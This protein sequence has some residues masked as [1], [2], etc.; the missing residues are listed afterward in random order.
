MPDKQYNDKKL[1]TKGHYKDV[2]HKWREPSEEAKK[3]IEEA[4]EDN[5]LKL[6]I[7]THGKYKVV[8]ASKIEDRADM[9]EAFKKGG[10][11]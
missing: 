5:T 1:M 4:D 9:I 3:V 10:D 8:K 11:K 2:E 7:D 6:Y